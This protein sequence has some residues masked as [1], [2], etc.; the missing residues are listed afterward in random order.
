MIKIKIMIDLTGIKPTHEVIACD[1]NSGEVYTCVT[2]K[3]IVAIAGQFGIEEEKAIKMLEDQFLLEQPEIVCPS[4]NT[5]FW[6]EE[7][8]WR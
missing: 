6:V 4:K 2:K 7:T 8:Y 1:L 5:T 3:A